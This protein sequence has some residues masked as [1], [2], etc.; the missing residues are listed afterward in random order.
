MSRNNNRS[1]RNNLNIQKLKCKE[2]TGK[3]ILNN[4]NIKEKF[5]LNGGAGNFEIINSEINNV[6][7][8]LGTGKFKY[9]GILKGNN[10]IEAGV[11]IKK[12][13]RKL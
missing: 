2:G 12:W 4:V 5:E 6:D 10:K 1:K 8:E 3:T 7:I 13:I 11:C 9:E